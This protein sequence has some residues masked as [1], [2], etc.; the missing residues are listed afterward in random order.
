MKRN[1]FLILT[2]VSLITVASC[3]DKKTSSSGTSAANVTANATAPKTASTVTKKAFERAFNFFIVSDW[4][5][6]GYKNQQKVA[7]AMAEVSDSIEPKF[8]VSCGDNFQVNGVESVSDP[9]WMTNFENVYRKPSLLCDWYP[10][11]GNHDY[12]G[13]AQSEIDYSRISRRWRMESHYYTFARKINDSVSVRFI[14]IDTPPLVS[15]YYRSNG[16]PD[17][18]QD[19]AKQIAWLK[20]TLSNSKENWKI[21]FGHHPVFSASKKHGN[22]PELINRIKPLFDQYC[23][24]YYFCGHDHDFQLLKEKEGNKMR[25][26]E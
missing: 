10:V 24:Q 17:I 9:L 25:I 22:T 5:W 15:E 2:I 16:Y 14:F 13:N 23:V 12:K 19:T 1:I 11:F 26:Y 4:G 20:S 21:V 6:N 3:S 7:D 18:K 8:I